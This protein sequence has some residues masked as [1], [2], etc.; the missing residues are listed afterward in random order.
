MLQIDLIQNEIFKEMPEAEIRCPV[1]FQHVEVQRLEKQTAVKH[2]TRSH[3]VAMALN[4]IRPGLVQIDCYRQGS[5]IPQNIELD[6]LALE[7]SFDDFFKLRALAFYFD[8]CITGDWVAVDSKK[9]VALA[10]N[11]VGGTCRD[12]RA[13]EHTAIVIFQSEKLSLS[14]V[15]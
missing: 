5:L 6:G 14:L 8:I 11:T 15:L 1:R 12:H 7:F 13:Y 10:K 4:R 3:I 2:V 9:D